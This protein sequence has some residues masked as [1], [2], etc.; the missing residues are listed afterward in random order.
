VINLTTSYLGQDL[1]NPLVCSA[2]PLC[3][4]VDNLLRMEEAG[5]GAVVL[6]SLFEEQIERESMDLSHFLEHGAEGYAE[7]LSYFPEMSDYNLGPDGYLSHVRRAKA[8]LTV[9]VIASLNGRSDG[10][11]ARYARQIQDA[12]AD[13]LEL[14]V[15]EMPTD[16]ERSGADVEEDLCRL[17]DRV[18]QEVYLPVAVK[19][20]SSY[21]APVH[22][23]KRLAAAGAKGL[24]LFNRFY[25]PDFDL[26]R[27]EVV[28]G[29]SLSTSAEL[30]QRL[31]WIALLHGR[32][33]A[34]LA[35]TGG[36]HTHQ[37]ALKALM[38]GASVVM[39][40]SALLRHGIDHLR[41]VLA[42]LEEW[43]AQREY[44]SLRSLRGS[45]SFLSAADPSAFVRANYVKVLRSHA[46]GLPEA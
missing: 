9:P 31:T 19:L 11:W 40:T 7:S 37:D 36:V 1:R 44:L 24:V 39:M 30:R 22:L 8:E 25:Q 28:P 18:C 5:A 3:Q 32:V 38:A 41:G 2:S 34:D 16:P 42:G 45:M 15:Y 35:V 17:V 29:L 27:L 13:A 43:M 14:N 26:D 10:S 23:A 4:E 6:H 20:G 12:G 21:T 33:K 46:V